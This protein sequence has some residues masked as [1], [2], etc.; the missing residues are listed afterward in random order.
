MRFTTFDGNAIGGT[1]VYFC[2]QDGDASAGAIS[3]DYETRPR[4]RAAPVVTRRAPTVRIIPFRIEPVSGTALTTFVPTVNQHFRPLAGKRT[5]QAVH[6]DGSTAIQIA[7]D[8]ITLEL[9][10][11]GHAFEGSFLLHD[12]YWEA[13]SATVDSVSPLS[14]AGTPGV[15]AQPTLTITPAASTNVKRIRATVSDTLAYG[16]A[17]TIVR[18][19]FDSTGVGLISTDTNRFLVVVNGR[20]VP[21]YARNVNGAATTIDVRLNVPA[22]GFGS[23]AVDIWFGAGVDVNPFVQLLELGG[24][25]VTHATFSNT[26]LVW[27]SWAAPTFADATGVWRL[28]VLGPQYNGVSFGIKEWSSTLIVFEVR[29]DRTLREDADALILVLPAEAATTNALTGI[30]VMISTAQPLGGGMGTQINSRV[31]LYYRTRSSPTWI[32]HQSV[33]T[34]S[35]VLTMPSSIPGAIALALV[36]EPFGADAM[37]SMR[38]STQAATTPARL[39]MVGGP[40]VSMAA[41]VAARKLS[42]SLTNTTTGATIT[43]PPTYLDA[44][45]TLTIDTTLPVTA[46]PIRTSDGTPLYGMP[47]FSDPDSLFPLNYGSNAWTEMTG[48]AT[49]FSFRNRYAA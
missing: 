33:N 21:Y 26:V 30:D 22:T 31:C 17:D 35:S 1:S 6:D 25:A 12:T 2:Y 34:T 9:V 45:A 24:I 42:G 20:S 46:E 8:V 11:G 19:T 10:S 41:A 4:R 39:T 3:L 36:L 49:S 14:V 13:Q 32:L 40:T 29:A 44:T 28:G 15:T 38:V 16:F 37:G 18:L 5:L 23:A 47:S 43:F 48:G 7:A 27:D